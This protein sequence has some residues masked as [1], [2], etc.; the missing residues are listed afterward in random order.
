MLT[1]QNATTSSYAC[2]PKSRFFKFTSSNIVN[3]G[4]YKTFLLHILIIF[5]DMTISSNEKVISYKFLILVTSKPR[6][7]KFTTSNTENLR[8]YKTFLLQILIIFYDMTIGSN[9]EVT[10]YNFLIPMTSK[11]RFF[12]FTTSNT[13]NLRN[14]KT[15]LIQIL[16]IFYDMTIG[17]NE[18]V[19]SY[20][21]LILVTS[22]PRFIKFTTSNTENLRNYKTFLLQI[23]IIF[24]D[25]TIGSNEEVTSYK[26]L[27][28]VTS[29]PRFFK[30]TTW[31]TEN[32]RNY[33]TFLIQILIIFYVMT[34]GSNEEVISYNFLILVTSKPR[35][36]KFTTSNTENLRNYK[37]FL[38]QILIIFMIWL[39]VAMR[40]WYHT[41]SSYWWSSNQGFSG[42]YLRRK[43][44][45]EF[46]NF[47][48]HK[49][50]I[51]HCKAANYYH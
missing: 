36:F 22:K 21:F 13:E 47:L 1:G 19:I 7:F 29:K 30:F 35:F 50:F 15:F 34:I 37:T 18:E 5:Y 12:K 9:E 39:L 42:H 32:L 14:Y 45:V 31:N 27:I 40:K 28:L 4:K 23:L 26:F 20:N 16:I 43:E 49:L 10:S 38:L 46:W 3:L 2:P 41:T 44:I 8:N 17:S 25:M 33:K 48:L 6:F 11:P 24:Y 51:G